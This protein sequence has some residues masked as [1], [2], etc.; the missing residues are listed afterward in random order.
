MTTTFREG[1]AAAKKLHPNKAFSLLSLFKTSHCAFSAS[2]PLLVFSQS[3][4][5]RTISASQFRILPDLT[6]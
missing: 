5:S 6:T 1:E 3:S 4:A 2:Y